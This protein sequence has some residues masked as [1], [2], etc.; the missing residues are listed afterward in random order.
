MTI[1]KVSEV[2]YQVYD[3]NFKAKLE[4]SSF[5]A[6]I[7]SRKTPFLIQ[8]LETMLAMEYEDKGFILRSG[9]AIGSDLAFEKGVRNPKNKEIY[10]K[11][12][13]NDLSRELALSF[14]SSPKNLKRNKIAWDLMARNAYQ[15]LGKDLNSPV[16]FV[17]CYTPDGCQSG[18]TRSQNT[19]GTGQ[20]ISIASYFNIP[21]L[22]L[23]NLT[24]LEMLRT[25]HLGVGSTLSNSIISVLNE[26]LTYH[27]NLI[28]DD[29]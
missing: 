11:E 26:I 17:I 18:R 2:L 27:R 12:D 1:S 16:N 23:A 3:D 5:Y 28:I 25:M 20:A 8:E 6:G 21:V 29:R 24:T 15:I 14:H 13:A 22:N 10:Y 9:G 4:T 7:G 19:G